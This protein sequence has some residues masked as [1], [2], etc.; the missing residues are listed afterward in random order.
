MVSAPRANVRSRRLIQY[1]FEDVEYGGVTFEVGQTGMC[2]LGSANRDELEYEN[3]DVIDIRRQVNRG[4]GFGG[5]PHLCLGAPLA[6]VQLMEALPR[7]FRTFP[8]MA[9]ASAELEYE[10]LVVRWRKELQLSL[11]RDR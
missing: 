7:L 9:L 10:M 11:G 6:R 3:S 8:G 1:V 4:V 5:G 2:L